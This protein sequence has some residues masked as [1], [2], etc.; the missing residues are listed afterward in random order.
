M[1]LKWHCWVANSF[2]AVDATGEKDKYTDTYCRDKSLL[3]PSCPVLSMHQFLP[4]ASFPLMGAEV[5]QL[6]SMQELMQDPE[7]D[8]IFWGAAPREI[9]P[10]P[11]SVIVGWDSQ[12]LIPTQEKRRR[13]RLGFSWSWLQ[14]PALNS[15]QTSA[16]REE[17]PDRGRSWWNSPVGPKI[18]TQHLSPNHLN[19]KA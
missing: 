3:V 8:V 6:Q 13:S 1:L 15:L 5:T 7:L 11:S 16:L 9:K 17:A 14:R 18:P 2:Q 10:L 4:P 19:Q 12:S